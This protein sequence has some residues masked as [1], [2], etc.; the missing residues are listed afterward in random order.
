LLISALTYGT[1]AA[2]NPGVNHPAIALLHTFS[3][4]THGND[5]AID[6]MSQNLSFTANFQAFASAKLKTTVMQVDVRMTDTTGQG[7]N[8]HFG[9]AWNRRVGFD[10]D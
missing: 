2:A 4:R 6:L 1:F 3:I 10:F 5:L 9:A 7:F 8:Q